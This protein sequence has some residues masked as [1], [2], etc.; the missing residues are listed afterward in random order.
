MVISPR[1]ANERPPHVPA[2]PPT[3][4][5]VAAEAGDEPIV[6]G[7]NFYFF[8]SYGG[9]QMLGFGTTGGEDSIFKHLGLGRQVARGATSRR[10]PREATDSSVPNPASRGEGDQSSNLGPHGCE[11]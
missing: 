3:R 2:M 8:V 1:R 7:T 6:G 5:W 4:S 11:R 9:S 10:D